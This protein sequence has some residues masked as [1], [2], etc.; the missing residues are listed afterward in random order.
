MHRAWDRLERLQRAHVGRQDLA[1]HQDARGTLRYDPSFILVCFQ[2]RS[3]HVTSHHSHK[4]D[5]RIFAKGPAPWLR[6][7]VVGRVWTGNVYAARFL[8]DNKS[9]ITGAA[10]RTVRVW[11]TGEA[12]QW[13]PSHRGSRVISVLYG[14]RHDAQATGKLFW[15]GVAVQGVRWC[16]RCCGRGRRVTDST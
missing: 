6:C 7:R 15:Y 4:K 9:V 1:V 8:G 13:H 10:D 16:V 11:D 14:E 12:R 2:S 5:M 3:R